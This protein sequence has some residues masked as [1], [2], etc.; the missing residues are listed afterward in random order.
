MKSA[1]SGPYSTL[2]AFV[3]LSWFEDG[4]ILKEID[5]KAAPVKTDV[6]RMSIKGSAN[7]QL[8]PILRLHD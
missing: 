4:K 7:V 1:S 3:N 2:R 5:N 8:F 6:T